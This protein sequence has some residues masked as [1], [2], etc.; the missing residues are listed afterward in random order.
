M[1]ITSPERRYSASADEVFAAAL[2]TAEN[3]GYLVFEADPELRTLAVDTAPRNAF[4]AE[5]P[6]NVE[7]VP[8]GAGSRVV[9]VGTLVRSTL[10]SRGRLM[11]NGDRPPSEALGVVWP[12]SVLFNLFR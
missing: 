11:W 10:A 8:D 7:V 5:Q 3:L 4:G 9:M 6:I 2:R 1:A 12:L